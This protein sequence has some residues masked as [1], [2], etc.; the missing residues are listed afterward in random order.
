MPMNPMQ[1]RARNSF[2]IGFLVALVIMAVVV[3]LLLQKI[4]SINDAKEALE[5]KQK[6][7]LV[8]TEDLESGDIVTMD[9]FTS[10]KVQTTMDVSQIISDEDFEFLDE[11]GE[12]VEKYNEDGSIMKKE[13]VMKISV[14]AK[15]MVTKDMVSE[16]DNQVTK[17]LRM[18]EFNM[19][20]LPSQLK[21]GDYVD[22]R[23][24]LPTGE[25]YIVLP[26]KRV[27]YTTQTG[28]WL[29]L[30]EDELL[31]IENAIVEAYAID[32]SRIYAIQYVEPGMQDA[33][34][35]TYPVNQATLTLIQSSPNIV[36]TAKDALF[37]RYNDQGQVDQRVMHIDASLPETSD[38][39]KAVKKGHSAEQKTIQEDREEFVKSLEGTDKIG[40][41][42]DE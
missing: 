14:P 28:I 41:S 10:E 40:P 38:I 29:E 7:V 4:K 9:M 21:N 37:A 39:K 15:T 36:Q 3:M 12:I 19:I 25:N 35:A 16:I 13:L 34:I 18:Q 11:Y 30:T 23:Y 2:L 8:C 6:T 42:T 5:A 1:R 22:I 20:L 31:T 33:A 24:S 17:D 26:K 27:I 32:G